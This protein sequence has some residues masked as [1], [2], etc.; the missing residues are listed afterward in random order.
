[1]WRI[2]LIKVINVRLG[3]DMR[4]RSTL[5][6]RAFIYN[7]SKTV[8]PL[9]SPRSRLEGMQLRLFVGMVT[10]CFIRARQDRTCRGSTL[11][12][13]HFVFEF[14]SPLTVLLHRSACSCPHV[15][16]SRRRDH[17]VVVTAR[18]ETRHDNRFE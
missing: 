13:C 1:M 16:I 11:S 8:R 12:I 6:V 3:I 15:P 7:F 18:S 9:F 10:L 5:S 2:L 17:R 14:G 4:R